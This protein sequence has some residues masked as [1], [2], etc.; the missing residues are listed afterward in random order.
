MGSW[1]PY[2][3]KNMTYIQSCYSFIQFVYIYLKY[4]MVL[5]QPHVRTKEEEAG[6]L[7]LASLEII[8]GP[9]KHIL[10]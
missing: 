10:I 9:N 5:F 4:V 6:K 8:I 1:A 3:P 2:V 7:L